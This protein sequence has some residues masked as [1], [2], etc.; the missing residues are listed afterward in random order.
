MKDADVDKQREAKANLEQRVSDLSKSDR[1]AI[2]SPED[3]TMTELVLG[4]ASVGSGGGN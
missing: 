3:V 4:G 1:R 2:T